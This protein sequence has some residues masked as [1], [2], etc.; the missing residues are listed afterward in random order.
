MLGTDEVNKYLNILKSFKKENKNKCLH[1][2]T[3]ITVLDQCGK[4]ELCH[5]CGII[6]Q[7]NIEL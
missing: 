1:K 5:D 3:E 2:N 7:K 6:V 4:V